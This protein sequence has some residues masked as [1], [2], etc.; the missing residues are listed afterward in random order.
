MVL[1]GRVGNQE[2]N[3]E[4]ETVNSPC[5]RV[6]TK[7]SVDRRGSKNCLVSIADLG[8]LYG[9]SRSY[10]SSLLCLRI[11]GKVGGMEA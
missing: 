11:V 1:C 8:L 4:R 5:R 9:G 6:L 3:S 10:S 7:I 2:S